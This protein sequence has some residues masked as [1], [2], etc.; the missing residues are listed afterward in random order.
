MNSGIKTIQIEKTLFEDNNA[1]AQKV[2]ESADKTKTFLINVMA[3]P[4]AGKTSLIK[5]AAVLL[6]QDF[7]CGV[8]EGDVDSDIDAADIAS[9]GFPA[10]Q[11]NTGGFCHLDA[12]MTEEAIKEI[13]AKDLD[14]IFIENIGNL[15]CPSDF[16]IGAHMSLVIS[17][18]PEG[19]DKADKYPAMFTKADCVCVNKIDYLQVQEYDVQRV[20]SK[21]KVL[22]KRAQVFQ[23]SAKTG[24]GVTELV[25]YIRGKVH[26]F[27]KQAEK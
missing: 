22:N 15:I 25:Q 4:G 12:A 11:I 3:S 2:R 8:I 17:S 7:R 20:K 6:Q 5:A 18:V 10:V 1:I 21:V 19:D 9:A 27:F 14:I 26:S 24:E 23:V 13:G 16:D